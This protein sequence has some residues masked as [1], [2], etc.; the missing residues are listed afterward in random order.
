MTYTI[1]EL[2]AL[3]DAQV[4]RNKPLN[5]FHYDDNVL[6]IEAYSTSEDD[7]RCI[8]TLTQADKATRDLF[9]AAVEALPEL[10]A[11]IRELDPAFNAAPPSD[12]V[13]RAQ[14]LMREAGAKRAKLEDAL[15][16]AKLGSSD[17]LR[18]LGLEAYFEDDGS[19]KIRQK[20][21][22]AAR[23]GA[24]KPCVICRSP[25]ID[26]RGTVCAAHSDEWL[27]SPE[28]ARVLATLTKPFDLTDDKV[29]SFQPDPIAETAFADFVRRVQAERLNGRP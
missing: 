5:M 18:A 23:G 16:K 17:E 26:C 25:S 10:I 29:D 14:E 13:A 2:E 9:K 20:R 27:R 8:G 1:Q 12:S 6:V 28:G 24:V 19:V 3:Y 7:Y 15:A 22:E 11:K 4:Q 21:R